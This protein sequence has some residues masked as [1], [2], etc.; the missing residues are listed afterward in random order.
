MEF[1]LNDRTYSVGKLDARK[2]LHVA[3]R[4]GPLLATLVPVLT[5]VVKEKRSPTTDEVLGAF[6]VFL[7]IFASMAD[8]DVDFCIFTLMSVA[9]R[10]EDKGL[11]WARITTETPDPGKNFSTTMAYGDIGASQMMQIAYKSFE[12]N[13]APFFEELLSGLNLSSPEPSAP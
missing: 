10:K 8:D 4:M 1:A 7:Q 12:V 3:R 5:A 13:V 9:T 11:G 6:P 2:S